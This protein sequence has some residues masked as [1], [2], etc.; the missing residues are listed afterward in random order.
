ML[1]PMRKFQK[2]CQRMSQ[3]ASVSKAVEGT[4]RIIYQ[5]MLGSHPFCGSCSSAKACSLSA[6]LCNLLMTDKCTC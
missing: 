4:G 3:F 6:S 5:G 2:V 1:A